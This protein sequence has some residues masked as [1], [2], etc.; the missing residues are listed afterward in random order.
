MAKTRTK[1]EKQLQHFSIACNILSDS[2]FDM[3]IEDGMLNVWAKNA[4]I[5]LDIEEGVVII[6]EKVKTSVSNLIKT[7]E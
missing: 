2:G 5:E 6:P 1:A 3:V 7:L 4:S